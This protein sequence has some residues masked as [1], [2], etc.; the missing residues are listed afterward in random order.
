MSE[1]RT[2]QEKLQEETEQEEHEHHHNPTAA[3]MTNHI[4]ANIATLHVK[5]HQYHWY[6]KGPHF[7]SL[8]ENCIMKTKN[9][10]IK[11][12]NAC[13]LPATNHSRLLLS[14]NNTVS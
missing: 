13:L 6:V 11:L 9:G 7:F 3:A 1:D 10:S 2:V 12:P 14:S 8:H 4:V 5:L